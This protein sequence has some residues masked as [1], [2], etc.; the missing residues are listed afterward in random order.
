[1]RGLNDADAPVLQYA[2][3]NVPR[4]LGAAENSAGLVGEPMIG[5]EDQG[6]ASSLV[7]QHCGG[8]RPSGLD[9]Q[10]GHFRC[11]GTAR[12][13]AAQQPDEAVSQ[14]SQLYRCG[15]GGRVTVTLRLRG[16]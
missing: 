10:F 9:Q 16:V 3:W 14:S 13:F 2:Q 12:P 4:A 5:E 11:E 1:M 6:A 7:P 15:G 8:L